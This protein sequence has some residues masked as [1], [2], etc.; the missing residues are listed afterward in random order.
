ML[1]QY[2]GISPEGDLLLIE[3]LCC[4]LEGK[5]FLHINSTRQGGGVAEILHRMIPLL[6]EFGIK[7]RWEVIEG[8]PEFFDVTKKIHNSLQGSPE[9]FTPDM[10]ELHYEINRKN[11]QEID[12][13]A[14]GV[15][16]HDPQPMPLIKFRPDKRGF[17]FWRCHI[18]MSSP[19]REP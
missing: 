1:S 4:Q 18:D 5:S 2:K 12:L 8:S 14:D 15:F 11:A 16:I 10:W 17:W 3:R 6:K 13:E 19:Q 7:A 9:I